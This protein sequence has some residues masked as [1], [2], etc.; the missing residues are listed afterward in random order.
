MYEKIKSREDDQVKAVAEDISRRIEDVQKTLEHSYLVI[1]H[2]AGQRNLHNLNAIKNAEDAAAKEAIA[3]EIMADWAVVEEITED[4][5]EEDK[6]EFKRA[7]TYTEDQIKDA[8][9]QDRFDNLGQNKPY[10]REELKVLERIIQLKYTDFKTEK[11]LKTEI[12]DIRIKINGLNG[13][14]KE[15]TIR[16]LTKLLDQAEI[17]L[18]AKLKNKDLQLS[19]T[20]GI[21]FDFNKKLKLYERV[22]LP[23]TGKQI[24]DDSMIMKFRR[25]LASLMDLL[26]GSADT[27]MTPAGEAFANFGAMV[28]N[29]Y[30]KTLNKTAKVVGKALKGREGEMKADAISR[31]F[32]PGPAVLDIKKEAAFEEASAPGVSPQMPGSIGSMGPITPPTAT[33][34]GSGDN[35]NPM[36]KIKKKKKATHILEFSDF[37]KQNKL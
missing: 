13:L 18:L 1:I 26:L 37:L 10:S 29:I 6:E 23:V 36:K 9:G 19:R 21:H 7:K 34:L 12:S 30:A 3:D 22:A 24:A 4:F 33:T 27:P 25:G 14:S 8:I 31:M 17:A 2:S 28:H 16:E 35:F 20:K 5:P 15:D 32:I 11:E